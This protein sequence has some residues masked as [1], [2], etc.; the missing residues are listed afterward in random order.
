MG[1]AGALSPLPQKPTKPLFVMNSYILMEV[2]FHQLLS[3]RQDN[4]A[5]ATLCVREYDFQ[6]P[7]GVIKANR[8]Q[9]RQIDEKPIQRFFVSA[10]IYV[11]EPSVIQLIPKV[12]FFDMPQLLE[13]I[14]NK[15]TGVSAFPIHEYWIDIGRITDLELAKCEFSTAFQ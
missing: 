11:L 15:K 2:N 5:K 1:T 3:F 14:L 6:V 12:Q 7:Y 13:K 9:V 4:N 10:G 8:H